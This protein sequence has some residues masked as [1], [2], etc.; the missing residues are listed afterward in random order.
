MKKGSVLSGMLWMIFLSLILFWLPVLGPLI[1]GI[2]GG[3][4]AGGVIRALVACV[5]PAF[6]VSTIFWFLFAVMGAPLEGFVV[7]G[8]VA[9]SLVTYLVAY[10]FSL[11][12]GAIVGGALA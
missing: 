7:A 6:I 9:S 2:V 5:L 8:M 3:R 11:I 1:A 12:C 4:K 10:D